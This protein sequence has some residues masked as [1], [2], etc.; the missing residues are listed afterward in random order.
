MS[1][2][3]ALQPDPEPVD[4]APPSHEGDLV[5][6]ML[7]FREVSSNLAAQ[8]IESSDLAIDLIL[9]DIAERALQVTGASGSAIAIEREGALVCRAAAG[10]TA[11]D[12]GVKINVQSGL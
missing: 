8:G 7:G 10:S 5:A 12:L 1:S 9:H 11:P 3:S 6:N 2:T 4:P